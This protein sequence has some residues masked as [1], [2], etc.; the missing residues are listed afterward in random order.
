M[1]LF[2]PERLERFENVNKRTVRF[3]WV[4]N[5]KWMT[6][7]LK[8][9]NTIIKPAIEELQADGYDVEL[10]TSDRLNK[11][12]PHEEMPNFY[13]QID[14]Y[15]CASVSEGTPNP[16]LESMACGVPVISTDVGL[17]PEVFGPKQMKYVLEERSVECLKKKMKQLIDTAGSFRELSGENLIS[18]QEWD[19]KI[20]AENIR[21]YFR[22]CLNGQKF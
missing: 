17:I 22:G 18:I 12:I 6:G 2:R 4:G 9:I 11:L 5:S 7:D 10:I 19:W 16:V 3:G 21:D 14:C 15:I 1:S 13:N 8:G 20:K